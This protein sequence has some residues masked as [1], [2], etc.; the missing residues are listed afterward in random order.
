ML[1]APCY[2]G[3][4]TDLALCTFCAKGFAALVTNRVRCHVAGKGG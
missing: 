3:V 4:G 2:V 1:Q